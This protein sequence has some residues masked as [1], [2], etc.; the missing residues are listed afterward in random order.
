MS[1]VKGDDR[2]WEEVGQH[3]GDPVVAIGPC[4][5]ATC[6]NTPYLTL[7]MADKLYRTGAT[8]YCPAGHSQSWPGKKKRDEVKAAQRKAEQA[9]ADAE[10]AAAMREIAERTCPWPTCDG[11][12]LASPRGLRQHMVKAHGA[13]WVSPLLEVEEVGQVLNGR[14][15][16]DVVR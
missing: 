14:D 7:E 15:P 4:P 1:R 3:Y 12:V 9:K 11:R 5:E 6:G 16:A 13:P 8:F 10:H 2:T